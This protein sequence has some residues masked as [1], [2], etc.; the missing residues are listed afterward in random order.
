MGRHPAAVLQFS[1]G[2][3]NGPCGLR[4]VSRWAAETGAL[5]G[6]QAANSSSQQMILTTLRVFTPLTPIFPL[7]WGAAGWTYLDFP[8]LEKSKQ[9]YTWPVIGH[10]L[11]LFHYLLRHRY[12]LV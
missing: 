10:V 7:R 4:V 5:A 9:L 2:I 1:Q 3:A 12:N 6:C 11:G 8:R